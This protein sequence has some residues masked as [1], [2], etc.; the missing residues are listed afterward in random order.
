MLHG[1]ATAAGVK[2]TRRFNAIGRTHAIRAWRNRFAMP[3]TF[4]TLENLYRHPFARERIFRL[5]RPILNISTSD[6]LCRDRTDVKLNF[7]WAFSFHFS[8]LTAVL[9]KLSITR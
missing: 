7:S 5:D 6:T 1:T 4:T 8:N 3:D 2:T 9:S